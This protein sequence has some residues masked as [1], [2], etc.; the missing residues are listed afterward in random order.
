[1]AEVRRRLK[2]GAPFVAAHNSFPQEPGVRETWFDR[3]AGFALG[4]GVDRSEVEGMQET[5]Q[6]SLH[7]MSPDQDEAML[8]EAGFVGTEL[9]Y[10]GLTWRG[11]VT[12]AP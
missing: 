5:F 2:P 4:S 3:Y 11:W 1:L 7:I 6:K 12:Y 10:A 9:F 8:A